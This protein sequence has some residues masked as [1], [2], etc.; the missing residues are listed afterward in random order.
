MEEYLLLRRYNTG[1]RDGEYTLP[2]GHVDGNETIRS[3]LRREAMEEIGISIKLSDCAHFTFSESLLSAT[4]KMN[5]DSETITLV[6][7]YRHKLCGR[8]N[9]LRIYKY[10]SPGDI[11]AISG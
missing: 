5:A 11:S 1:W 4:I 7:G 10:A 2:P 8:G 3:E 6:R 9:K